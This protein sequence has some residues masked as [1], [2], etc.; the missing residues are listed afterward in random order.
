MPPHESISRI[1]TPSLSRPASPRVGW[2][3]SLCLARQI[4]ARRSAPE[5]GPPSE[6]G[7]SPRGFGIRHAV[8]HTCARRPE[9]DSLALRN[10]LT[11]LAARTG[12]FCS[13]AEGALSARLLL[14]ARPGRT[15]GRNY[16]CAVGKGG[17][18]P[19]GRRSTCSSPDAGQ[20][21]T[22]AD[23]VTPVIGSGAYH[24]SG[25]AAAFDPWSPKPLVCS[26][27]GEEANAII[28]MPLLAKCMATR[29]PR[30]GPAW[31]L[32]GSARS[33]CRRGRRRVRARVCA[34]KPR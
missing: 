7:G 26:V 2:Q 6:Q 23:G 31:R 5:V 19:T 20:Q 29:A 22:R 32:R 13:V 27:G 33:S 15:T 12:R 3:A 30:C 18:R 21:R 28:P 25:I 10:N 34:E 4:L 1:L 14:S 11:I 17:L 16:A 8:L 24:S 9:T